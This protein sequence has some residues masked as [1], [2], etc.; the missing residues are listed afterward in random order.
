M[1]PGP[2]YN[3]FCVAYSALNILSHAAHYRAAQAT[4]RAAVRAATAADTKLSQ[5][6]HVQSS[7]ENDVKLTKP[8]M[9]GEPSNEAPSMLNTTPSEDVQLGTFD[10]QL[11]EPLD[12]VRDDSWDTT[13]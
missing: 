7:T 9:S 8:E 6:P 3:W 13:A 4:Q 5:E 11:D 2:A 10:L 12:K 1:P